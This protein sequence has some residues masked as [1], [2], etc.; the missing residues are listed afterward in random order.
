MRASTPDLLYALQTST[1]HSWV[2][3]LIYDNTTRLADLPLHKPSF[4][5]DGNA[6]IV[7]SGSCE[8]VSQD[9]FGRS[10]VPAVIGDLFSPFGA[11]LQVDVI[12]TVG[13][14]AER[15]PM[16][17]YVLDS[18]PSSRE[19]ELEAPGGEPFFAESRLELS[20]K[21]YMLRVQRDKFPFP[22]PPSSTSMWEEAFNLTGLALVRNLPDTPVP[23]SVTYDEDR[24]QALDDL[25]AVQDAWP[26]LTPSG[27]LTARPKGWPAPVSEF[28]G[29]ASAPRT[30]ESERVYNRVVVEG[31]SPNG[32]VIRAI[33]EIT[34]GF[35]RVRN[36]DGSRSPFGAAT[37]RYQSDF[38]TTYLQCLTTAQSMLGRVSRLSSVRRT[39]VEK[40][41]PLREV[42]DVVVLDGQLTRIIGISHDGATTTSEVEVA[43]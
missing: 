30:M 5:W 1:N 8:I 7:G 29:V 34:E 6:Q 33:A 42:G 16:G 21:D 4:S 37:Y 19:V 3:S 24:L 27:Q 43:E 14:F 23:T 11:E 12:V 39:V 41:M 35:L 31:K 2:G 32:D 13:D 18:V 36:S 28:R 17:R 38:L 40:F 20:L 25:F 26:H 22:T 15:I 10:I 9:A